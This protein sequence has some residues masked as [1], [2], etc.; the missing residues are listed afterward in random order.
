MLGLGLLVV[1]CTEPQPRTPPQARAARAKLHHEL[2]E[3]LGP[4]DP[5]PGAVEVVSEE[6]FKGVQRAELLI[7]TPDGLKMPAV[8]LTPPG[9]GPHPAILAIHGHDRFGAYLVDSPPSVALRLAEAGFVVLAPT[10]RSFGD[11]RAK[12]LNHNAYTAHLQRE[13]DVF[14]RIAVND[15]RRALA[16]LKANSK[17]DTERVGVLGLSLGGVIAL[18]TTAAEPSVAAAEIA[19]IFIPYDYL[20]NPKKAH[21]CQS[22][23]GLEDLG[24]S[25]DLALSVAPR[26]LSIQWGQA[27]Q[28]I[29]VDL[30]GLKHTKALAE[31]AAREGYT[32]LETYISP[33]L[34]HA[35]D[36]P[37]HVDFF[38]RALQ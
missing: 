2:V 27:D 20:L 29:A 11:F 10:I 24:S 13:D 34:G 22:L 28:K 18:L 38:R 5:A 7:T 15:V 25:I 4:F 9:P 3:L 6:P 8:R 12:G 23:E 35:F 21:R 31:Q 32:N 1:G 37:R 17:V 33:G 19:G 14:L 36:P 16:V 30:K 26:P